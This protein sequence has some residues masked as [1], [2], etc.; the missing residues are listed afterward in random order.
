MNY[1]YP[2]MKKIDPNRVIMEIRAGTGGDEA[3]LFAGDLYRMYTKF[4]H[5]M[6]W[7]VRDISKN[8]FE[9][10]A[11]QG[12]PSSST[13]P[14]DAGP[15]GSSSQKVLPDRPVLS[16]TPSASA[17]RLVR[18]SNEKEIGAVSVSATS[19]ADTR[20][21]KSYNETSVGISSDSEVSLYD[22][23]KN[24]SGVHRV[25]RIPV[26]ERGG[27]LHTSTAT[28]AVL[29]VVNPVEFQINP[30]DLKIDTYRSGGAGGQNV[31]KVETAVR[32]THIPTGVVVACQDERSQ[33]QNKERALQV[34]KS[35]LFVM[36]Q[37]QQKGSIDDL[38]AS[39]I[40]TGERSEKIRTYNF[41]QDRLTDHRIKKTWHNLEKIMEG[42]LEA[43]LVE[44]QKSKGK[45][46]KL[47][48]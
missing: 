7:K 23:L 45:R 8:V 38:R 44:S 31:N 28:V 46:Q 39:Q 40:G 1:R 21:V 4:A 35:K 11:V 33:L 34:L 20:S 14:L 2:E 10:V 36:M 25:Q 12:V 41:P 37:E 48:V 13:T 5:N 24:E 17:T 3:A 16:G 43:I 15:A 29:P 26:T 32:V 22:M 27:R 6:G 30:S 9:V 47:K 19:A 42:G 18:Y